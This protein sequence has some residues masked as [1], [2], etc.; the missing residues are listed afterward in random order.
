MTNAIGMR[1]RGQGVQRISTHRALHPYIGEE[2]ENALANP[3]LFTGHSPKGEPTPGYEATILLQICEAVLTASDHGALKT[4]QEL[5][6]ADSCYVLVRSFAK[7]G[8]IG[9][10]DEATGYQFERERNALHK[11]LAAYIAEELLPWTKKFPDEFYKELF[12]LRVWTY[13]PSSMKRPSYVGK[14]TNQLVYDKLPPGVLD[15]LKRKNPVDLSTKRRRFRHHQFLSEDI[16]HPHLEKH[17]HAV[18][19]LMRASPNWNVFT[20]LFAHAFPTP[21]SY[22]QLE[23]EIDDSELHG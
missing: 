18:I 14:L 22:T 1:G 10:V 20:R 9:L 23:I 2:L 3:I 19:T 17:L 16:G 13:K 4:K 12:R 6:Y 21:D 11:L 15:E 7:I 8:I 5:R